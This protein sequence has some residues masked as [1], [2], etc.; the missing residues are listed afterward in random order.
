MLSLLLSLPVLLFVTVRHVLQVDAVVGESRGVSADGV[1]SNVGVG[2]DKPL[3]AITA[4]PAQV[5]ARDQT[6]TY[7]RY[8]NGFFRSGTE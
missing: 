7:T 1:N 3:T 8:C 4:A 5:A 6:R 2:Q